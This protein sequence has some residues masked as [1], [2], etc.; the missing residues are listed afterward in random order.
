VS[1]PPPVRDALASRDGREESSPARPLTLKQRK[2]V[3]EYLTCWNASEAARRAGYRTRADVAG[4]QILGNPSIR[5][6]IE[7]RLAE[8]AMS[9]D[10]V[11]TRLTD[12]ARCNVADFIR[13]GRGG[14]PALDLKRAEREGKLHL[15]SEITWT[16]HGP[17]VKLHDAQAALVHLGRHHQLFRDGLDLTTG[18]EKL[19]AYRDFDPEDV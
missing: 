6:A 4:A 2:F 1:P 16:E 3:E 5:A 15:I 8:A 7:E 19:K 11:L 10:E 18:G 14:K 13:I 9:A 12:Q 17:K